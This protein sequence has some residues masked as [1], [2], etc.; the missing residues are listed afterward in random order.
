MADDWQSALD[1]LQGLS[2]R[3][4]PLSRRYDFDQVT[5][6]RYPLPCRCWRCVVCSRTLAGENA[7]RILA[8]L[9]MLQRADQPLRYIT[10]TGRADG[11]HIEAAR[12]GW[13][14]M[15]RV[16]RDHGVLGPWVAVGHLDHR[17]CHLHLLVLT[18][19][20]VARLRETATGSGFGWTHVRSVGPDRGDAMR[21]SSYVTRDLH[22]DGRYFTTPN[23][24]ARPVRYASAWPAS[25]VRSGRR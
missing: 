10:L 16:L 17:G 13:S 11:L 22:R 7:Y 6:D 25:S 19:A 12:E 3:H 20:S 8:G 21:L 24:R 18:T 1:A 4:C 2:R 9:T 15:S 23:G 5:G 14:K